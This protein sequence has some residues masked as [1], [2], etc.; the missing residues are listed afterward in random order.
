[1]Q[2][3]FYETERLLQDNY[4]GMSR[5]HLPSVGVGVV[6]VSVYNKVKVELISAVCF[7]GILGLGFKLVADLSTG[8]VVAKEVHLP[9]VLSDN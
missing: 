8:I 2:N 9:C 6:T 1:M 3:H 7:L 5:E 4:A